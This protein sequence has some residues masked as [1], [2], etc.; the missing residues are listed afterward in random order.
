MAYE[1]IREHKFAILYI[2]KEKAELFENEL[3]RYTTEKELQLSDY[4]YSKNKNKLSFKLA[5]YPEQINEFVQA[6]AEEWYVRE[7]GVSEFARIMEI[8]NEEAEEWYELIGE[9]HNKS[10]ALSNLEHLI[11]T[12][13]IK[14]LNIEKLKYIKSHFQG[15]MANG[16]QTYIN[17]LMGFEDEYTKTMKRELEIQELLKEVEP[18]LI[19]DGQVKDVSKQ[20][21]ESMIKLIKESSVF[22]I[23]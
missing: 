12:K 18:L 2:K 23:Q 3:K 4:D 5:G 9:Q 17:H 20:Q 1:G 7:M 19:E 15:E 6:F 8:S 22:K 14:V 11:T 13:F 10:F 16:I 21:L